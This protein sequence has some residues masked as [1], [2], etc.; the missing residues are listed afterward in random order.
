M[1]YRHGV[2]ILALAGAAAA[3][4]SPRRPSEVWTRDQVEAKGFVWRGNASKE[5]SHD[6]LGA[7][8]LPKEYNWCDMDGKSYCSISRNQHIPQY[9]GSCWAHGAVSFW[10]TAS[11]SLARGRERTL[12]RRCSTS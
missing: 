5:S 8:D 7:T 1:M 4:G 6:L 11:R 10:R 12:T 9:C 3:S 2:L